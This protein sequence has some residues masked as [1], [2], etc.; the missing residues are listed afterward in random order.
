MHNVNET[1]WVANELG[2]HGSSSMGVSTLW[3]QSSGGQHEGCWLPLPFAVATIAGDGLEIS[4]IGDTPRSGGWNVLETPRLSSCR[5]V[6]F[7]NWTFGVGVVPL[8]K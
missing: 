7:A 8:L 6:S 1:F 2:G 5:V 3:Q 4:F